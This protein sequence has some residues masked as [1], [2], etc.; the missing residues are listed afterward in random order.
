[1]ARVGG[2]NAVMAWIAGVFCTAVV[3]ILDWIAVPMGPV[4]VQYV[5]DTLRALLPTGIAPS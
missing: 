5:G 3:V 2:R 4:V 1:M